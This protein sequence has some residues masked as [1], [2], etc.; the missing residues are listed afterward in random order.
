[1]WKS[2][3]FQIDLHVI[4]T[5]KLSLGLTSTLVLSLVTTLREKAVNTLRVLVYCQSL[6][7][8]ADPV[9][10]LGFHKEGSIV[11]TACDVCCGH[12]QF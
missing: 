6:D 10:E 7:T 5:M 12:A 9:V 2:V 11:N 8:C 3:P 1:M 4:F